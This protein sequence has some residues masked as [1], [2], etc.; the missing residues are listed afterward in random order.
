MT[1]SS[2]VI[3]LNRPKEF[4]TGACL[5]LSWWLMLVFPNVEFVKFPDMDEV[6][7]GLLEKALEHFMSKVPCKG[8]VKLHLSLKDYAKG[9]LRA[10]H[11]LHGTLIVD[12]KKY[13]AHE[14][15]WKLLEVIQDVLKKLEKEVQKE[16]SK[17]L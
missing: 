11:E 15:N 17:K 4:L 3:F 12:G 2:D 6:D 10:Q 5:I 8:E 7:L 14:T 1:N 16:H 13:F 9:G